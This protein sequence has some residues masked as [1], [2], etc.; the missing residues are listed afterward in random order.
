MMTDKDL[1]NIC[2]RFLR[3]SMQDDNPDT[4]ESLKT[5]VT[6]VYRAGER[7]GAQKVDRVV[8]AGA[9]NATQSQTVP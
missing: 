8:Q 2:V 5:V 1:H 9:S 6:N 7:A 4:L 3:L